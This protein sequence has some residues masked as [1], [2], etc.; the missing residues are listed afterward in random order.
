MKRSL[1]RILG[2]LLLTI[3]ICFGTSIVTFAAENDSN[4]ALGVEENSASNVETMSDTYGDYDTEEV[5][6]NGKVT[7]YPTL[8]KYVGMSRTFFL[9]TMNIYSNDDPSGTIDVWVYKP[10]GKLLKYFTIG[11]YERKDFKFTLPPSGRYTVDIKS[12]INERINVT[13]GW[14]K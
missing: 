6:P 13:A 9:S 5:S 3:T 7:L 10:D 4:V 8:N 2:S 11:G 12:N 14:T 1:S